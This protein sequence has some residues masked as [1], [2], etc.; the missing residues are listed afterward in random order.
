MPKDDSAWIPAESAEW[1]DNKTGLWFDWKQID[2]S[3]P[4]EMEP[5][6]RK[7][8]VKITCTEK[9]LIYP[10]SVQK[11]ILL[12]WF[13]DF[14]KMY[15]IANEYLD[16]LLMSQVHN[17][18]KLPIA[19]ALRHL[20]FKELRSGPLKEKRD[21]LLSSST[22][23]AHMVDQAICHCV[24]KYKTCLAN[25][26]NRHCRQFRIKN[27][28]GEK[29]NEILILESQEFSRSRNAICSTKLGDMK[30]ER[31]LSEV[32]TTSTLVYDRYLKKWVLMIPV[33]REGLKITSKSPDK[34]CGCDPGIRTFMTVYSEEA[35][36]EF[37]NDPGST[38]KKY[39]D[40]QDQL[41]SHL[42]QGKMNKKQYMKA[43]TRS[44]DKLT[45][46][47]TDMHWKVSKTLC[48]KYDKITIG[49]L[50]SQSIISNKNK[51]QLAKI[52]KRVS[53]TL[54]HYKFR[55]KLLHQAR[56]YG[57]IV[58]EKDEYMTTKTCSTCHN[59]NE[60]GKS[61]IYRCKFCRIVVGRD[62][63]AARNICNGIPTRK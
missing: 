41:K 23:N 59:V 17:V 9:M 25:L 35:V 36:H 4:R 60:V 62:V 39:Y 13:E 48:M 55:E 3:S 56:K 42:H 61:K 15:N 11:T 10:T 21:A 53:N 63:N 26:K 5:S 18:P 37:A 30:S 46:I 27:W 47:V 31:P 32:K 1:H 14:K 16:K 45:H 12:G 19:E 33:K 20:N 57:S 44:S 50:G 8:G 34:R 43:F 54:S 49:K 51:N 29:R 38:F 24:A 28:I 58:D 40:K 7:K 52:T 22:I 6:E 2:H